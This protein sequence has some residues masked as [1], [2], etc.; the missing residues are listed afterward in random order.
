MPSRRLSMH[1][2]PAQRPRELATL[3]SG[4][5]NHVPRL[6]R[7]Q[8]HMTCRSNRVRRFRVLLAKH[9][10]THCWCLVDELAEPTHYTVRKMYHKCFFLWWC[11]KPCVFGDCGVLCITFMFKSPRNILCFVLGWRTVKDLMAL[12]CWGCL[13]TIRNYP[14]LAHFT[15]R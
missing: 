1:S 10:G 12:L 8:R 9:S 2:S 14:L 7:V 13:R 6:R 3:I 11:Q 4:T 5:C 15:W